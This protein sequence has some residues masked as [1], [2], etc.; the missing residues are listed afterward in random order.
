MKKFLYWLP[1]ILSV[2]FICFLTL[3]SLDVFEIEAPW[4]QLIGGFLIHSIPS[5]VLIVVTIIAWKK[6]KIGGWLFMAVG[7]GLA[8]LT[9]FNLMSMVIYVSPIIVGILYLVSGK[10]QAKISRNETNQ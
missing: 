2:L 8:I 3:F 1:R 4:Y 6:P 5:L 7:L 9:K 10:S